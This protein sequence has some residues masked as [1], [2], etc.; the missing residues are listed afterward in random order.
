[1]YETGLT[2][3]L[4]LGPGWAALEPLLRLLLAA[5]MGMVVGWERERHG[6]AAGLR[7]HMLLCTGCALIMLI[8]LHIPALFA[9]QS[10]Q[11]IVRA[12]PG[13]I[14][15]HALSGLGFLGAGTI[16]VLGSKVRGLTTAASVWL[17]AAVG[18][19]VGAGLLVPAAWAWLLTMFALLLM[20]RL[21]KR[22]KKKDHYVKLDLIFSS[23]Q[24]RMDRLRDFLE[25]R[26]FRIVQCMPERRGDR[27]TYRAVLRHRFPRDLERVTEELNQAFHDQ[28]L[29]AV[30]WEE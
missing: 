19:A 17:T 15:G 30:K 28:G 9:D 23:A 20:S 12:D 10:A 7:T 1:M 25:S 11:G 29:E 3:M 2:E 16:I 27:I 8:S 22:M 6:R 21:E 26:S 13:R 24:Q 5:V 14:A 4:G 18:L